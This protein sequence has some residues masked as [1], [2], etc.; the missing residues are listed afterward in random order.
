MASA[1]T[2]TSGVVYTHTD[3]TDLTTGARKRMVE[4][5]IYSTDPKELPMRDIFGGYESFN[6]GSTKFEFVEDNHVA[7]KTTMSTTSVAAWNVG[8]TIADLEVADASIFCGGDI[9]LTA[10]GELVVVDFTTANIDE[11]GNTIHVL[12]RGDLGSTESNANSTSD[13]IWI[14]GNA[15]LEGFTYGNYPRFTQRTTKTNYTQIYNEDISVSKSYNQVPKFGIKD[16]FKYQIQQTT[17][18]QL[19]KLEMNVLYGN[20]N[21]GTLEGSATMPRTMGGIIG[22]GA[23]AGYIN[24]QTN[25]TNLSSA[26][27][28]ED[29]IN[30]AI[31][32]CYDA[33]ASV[34]DYVLICNS[35]PKKLISDFMTPYR[36][37]DFSEKKYGGVVDTMLCDFGTIDVAMN[38]Y[39]KQSDILILPKKNFKIGAFRPFKFHD[40]PD[41]KDAFMASITGEYTC[42]L[43]NEEFCAYLYGGATS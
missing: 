27:V 29:D 20:P 14:V 18:R 11:S 17:L 15:Q 33:G 12:G 24:I 23:T 34:T 4:D 1:N 21:T 3:S 26:D 10:D 36:K 39:I 41:T 13:T 42:K 6:P 5:F 25:T 30:S 31:Q 28:T 8:S 9:L 32:D 35:Y 40:L 19:K 37:A 7:V 22:I 43:V 16:E 2:V 38:R